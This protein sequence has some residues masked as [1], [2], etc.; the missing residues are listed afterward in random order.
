MI[1]TA[2][3]NN[4]LIIFIKF[5]SH[6]ILKQTKHES[7]DLNF[8]GNR[9]TCKEGKYVKIF[10]LPCL[11]GCILN[12]NN[13]HLRNKVFLFRADPI[14]KLCTGKQTRT[15]LSYLPLTKWQK[16][17]QV[18]ALPCKLQLAFMYDWKIVGSN[19]KYIHVKLRM[20]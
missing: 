14:S 20:K 15:H 4:D 8:K 12:E 2:A 11:Y 17:Y 13:L 6:N 18:Y 3:E 10:S 9:Y 7:V 16:N 1:P 19:I 5:I